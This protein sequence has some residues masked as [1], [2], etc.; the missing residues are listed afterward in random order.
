MM[1]ILLLIPR[2]NHIPIVAHQPSVSET[3]VLPS[4]SC[5]SSKASTATSSQP[6]IGEAVAVPSSC[7]SSTSTP[8]QVDGSSSSGCEMPNLL[9][10]VD[11]IYESREHVPGGNYKNQDGKAE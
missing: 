10:C 11:V 1:L 5:P 7:P 4:P 6:S 2:A 3:V 8:E 9:M